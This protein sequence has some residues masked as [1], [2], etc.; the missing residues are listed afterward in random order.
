MDMAWPS[1][2]AG[3]LGYRNNAPHLPSFAA[4]CKKKKEGDK[5]MGVGRASSY[6]QNVSGDRS[7][8]GAAGIVT[9][10]TGQSKKRVGGQ[11]GEIYLEHVWHRCARTSPDDGRTK[12]D[13]RYGSR[14]GGPA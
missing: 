5:V 6:R 13:L 8:C 10:A 3:A 9:K 12:A 4:T 2:L 14:R 7:P 1:S 11:E